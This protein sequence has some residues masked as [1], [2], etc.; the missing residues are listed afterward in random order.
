MGNQLSN[1]H[2]KSSHSRKKPLP[3]KIA[4]FDV[5]LVLS[6]SHT[7]TL[8]H[9][10]TIYIFLCTCI[11]RESPIIMAV[12]FVISQH[13]IHL[14]Y[15]PGVQSDSMLCY[16]WRLC[17]FSVPHFTALY[18]SALWTRS[19]EWQILCYKRRLGLFSVPHFTALHLSALWTRST[20]W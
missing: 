18:P 6:C 9:T 16:K 11:L 8:L 15:G 20:E 13:F 14:L 12:I 3:F 2:Q 5:Y 19:T 4:I 17:L 1:I 10:H 7:H